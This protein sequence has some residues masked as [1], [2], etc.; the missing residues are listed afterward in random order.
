MQVTTLKEG[1]AGAV[2]SK[3][4]PRWTRR[5]L[6]GLMHASRMQE[7]HLAKCRYLLAQK[8]ELSKVIDS[9]ASQN[10]LFYSSKL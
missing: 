3:G 8:E 6:F 1:M 2:R 7:K 5:C 4:S 10:V 9:N